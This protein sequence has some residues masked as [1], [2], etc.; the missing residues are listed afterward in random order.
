MGFTRPS[1]GL[2]LAVETLIPFLFH[3]LTNYRR[4]ST[5]SQFLLFTK[6]VICV[7]FQSLAIVTDTPFSIHRCQLYDSTLAISSTLL[8]QS[9]YP[10]Y[11]PFLSIQVRRHLFSTLAL[12]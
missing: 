11:F 8:I 4:L 10:L 2:P 9:S 1:V 12:T 3:Y 5:W 7:Y 6:L